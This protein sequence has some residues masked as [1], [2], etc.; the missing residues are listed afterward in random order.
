MALTLR[1]PFQIIFERK[2]L[3]EKELERLEPLKFGSIK[4]KSAVFATEFPVTSG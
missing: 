3:A 1:K 4:G 2:D